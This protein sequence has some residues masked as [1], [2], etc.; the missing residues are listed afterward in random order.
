AIREFSVI[1]TNAPAEYGRAAGAVQNLVIKSGTNEFKGSAYDFYRPKSLAATPKFAEEK[2]DFKNSDFG[3]TF[4]G[5]IVRDRTFFFGSYHGLRN[6]IPVEAG[7]Y[8]TVP[9]AKMRIGDFSELLDP[10]VS[11]LSQPVQIFDPVTGKPFAGNIIPP[12][13]LDPVSKAYLA[14][15]P[16][17]TRVGSTD[18]HFGFLPVGFG[19]DQNKALGIPGPGGVTTAN[20]ISLIGG[21]DGT[22]I[23]YL[24]DFGQYV[25]KQKAMQLSD[26]VTWL[27]G[28]HSFK[29]GG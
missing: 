24:G 25:I 22:Y 26:S 19:T 15:F 9:T 29:F 7:N 4:G 14:A 27:R 20:G 13:M 18:F 21:G 5:P 16:P 8:V 17:A 11:G 3:L 1:T 6:S 23:E 2:P 28:N 12:S 10:S